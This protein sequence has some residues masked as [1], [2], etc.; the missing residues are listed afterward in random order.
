M[1]DGCRHV[2]EAKCGDFL[3]T[4]YDTHRYGFLWLKLV[5]ITGVIT[6]LTL[7]VFIVGMR[8]LRSEN[9]DVMNTTMIVAIKQ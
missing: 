2:F 3:A 6:I 9:T 5:N 7:N 8:I 4:G 1:A